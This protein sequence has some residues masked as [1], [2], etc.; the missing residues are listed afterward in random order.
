MG[1]SPFKVIYGK[2]PPT[3]I[4]YIQGTSSIYVVDSLLTTRDAALQRRLRKA[5][6]VMKKT[7]DKHPRDVQFVGNDWVYVRLRPYQ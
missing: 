3:I 4:Q 5:Q 1:V 6:E 2:P 7:A